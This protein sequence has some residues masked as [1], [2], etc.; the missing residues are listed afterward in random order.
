MEIAKLLPGKHKHTCLL[1]AHLF[2]GWLGEN[3]RYLEWEAGL[4][5]S[6]C[7]TLEMRCYGSNETEQETQREEGNVGHV[8]TS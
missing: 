2:L 6:L 3:L 7:S 1:V 8:L 4:V 5:S